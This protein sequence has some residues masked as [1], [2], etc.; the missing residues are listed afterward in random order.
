MAELRCEQISA[1][2]GPD[3]ILAESI[4]GVADATL[5][6]ILGASGSGKTTLLADHGVHRRTDG[7]VTVGGTVVL[8]RARPPPA[9]SARSATWRRK[10]RSTRT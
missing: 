6:A 3:Q 10:A 4:F 9:R 5:T 7:S 8:R 1:S 2:Y